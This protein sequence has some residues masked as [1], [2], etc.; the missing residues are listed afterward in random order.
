VGSRGDEGALNLVWDDVDWA[1]GTLR[2]GSGSKTK[3][4]GGRFPFN[5]V[6]EV[7]QLLRELR[8][9]NEK[10]VFARANGQRLGYQFAL[11]AFKEA[12]EKA[13]V[14][15]YR[16]HDYRRSVARRLEQNGVPRTTAKRITGHRTD[17]VFEKYAV[18]E[19]DDMRQALRSV[20]TRL[21]TH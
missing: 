20:G 7:E 12:Q 15:P 2:V 14:G 4:P 5:E 16:L 11:A 21:G 8:G 9:R 1:S 17:Y 10:W 19:D 6:P 3:K 13:G 18:S